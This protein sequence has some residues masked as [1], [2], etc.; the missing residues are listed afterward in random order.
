M[1]VTGYQPLN[2]LDGEVVYSNP[3]THALLYARCVIQTYT[4]LEQ[5]D[6]N[7]D[8]WIWWGAHKSFLKASSAYIEFSLIQPHIR[9]IAFGGGCG[10]T[11]RGAPNVMLDLPTMFTAINS[12]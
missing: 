10:I 8:K 12:T 2:D 3:L 6:F 11:A 7:I 1:Q 4:Q 5:F 9:Y